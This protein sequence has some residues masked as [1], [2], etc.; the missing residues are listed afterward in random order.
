MEN[1]EVTGEE[2]GAGTGVGAAGTPGAGRLVGSAGGRTAKH[3]QGSEADNLGNRR[4]ERV[5]DGR[6]SGAWVSHSIIVRNL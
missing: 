5:R 2:A 3:G 1:K 6:Q 4:R